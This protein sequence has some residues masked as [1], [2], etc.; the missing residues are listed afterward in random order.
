MNV[1]KNASK[2]HLSVKTNV[3]RQISRALSVK[4][5][6]INLTLPVPI[7]DKEKKLT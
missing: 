2:Q 3:S 4:S 5:M 6:I 7:P 1:R